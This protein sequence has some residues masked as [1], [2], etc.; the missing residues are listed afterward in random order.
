M[1]ERESRMCRRGRDVEWE[2][3]RCGVG[4]RNGDRE[5]ERD[6]QWE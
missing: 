4:E 3:E 6:G 2:R 1:G 5:R